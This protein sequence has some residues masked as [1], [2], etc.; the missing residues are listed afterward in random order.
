MNA[1][2]QE[3]SQPLRDPLRSSVIV[4]NF[5]AGQ[6]IY[7]SLKSVLP[8]LREGS[9]EIVVL[10]NHSQDGMADWIARDLPQVSLLRSGENQG[11]GRGC[12]L[13]AQSCRGEFLVF[14]NPD[15]LVEAG[16]LEALLR[17]FSTDP[18]IGL[19]TAK[20][21]LM[22]SPDRINACGC[23]IHLS[24]LTLCRGMNKPKDQFAVS[25]PVA[26][27]SGAAFAIRR[28]LFQRLGGFDEHMFLY[29]EDAD[30]SWRARLA[31]WETVYTPESIVLHSYRL[32]LTP[33]KIF[34]EERNR[35]L[36]L[37]KSLKWGSLLVLTPCFVLAEVV[38]WGF[39]IMKDV[40]NFKNKW[41]A[42]FWILEKWGLIRQMREKTQELRTV[43]DRELL[44]STQFK[45][46]FAQ[47]SG[48][49]IAAL[50]SAILN[51]IFWLMRK[52][53]LAL[54]RW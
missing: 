48:P 47:A 41:S 23:D 24:G 51:P 37:L 53:T 28:D 17:P 35:Y 52:A 3:N 25:T 13:A 26:A 42:Y 44:K 40:R 32:R 1:I 11:F 8:T 4:V 50:A 15:T 29:L 12:N 18:K 36:M 54:I 14:L 45:L 5:N 49:W 34:W 16:W 27:V 9:D 22:E 2:P 38:A 21:L 33:L 20:I 39:V 43:S 30:L 10:D 6:K 31:G 46:D 19:V 7:N